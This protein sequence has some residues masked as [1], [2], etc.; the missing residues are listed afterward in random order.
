MKDSRFLA[1]FR[2]ALTRPRRGKRRRKLVVFQPGMELSSCQ[3]TLHRCAMRPL[4]A[5]PLANAYAVELDEADEASSVQLLNHRGIL[6]IDDDIEVK[7]APFPLMLRSRSQ[8]DRRFNQ[9]PSWGW[10]RIGAE[11]AQDKNL[12]PVPVAV[13]DTG[14]ATSHP[15]LRGKVVGGVNT[16]TSGGSYSDDN[17]HGT[18]V[19]GIIAALNNNFGVVGVAPNVELYAVKVLDRSGSGNLSDLIEGLQWCID[20][21]IRLV[22]LSLSSERT[23]ETF[24]EAVQEVHRRGVTMVCAAGNNGPNG[25]INYPSR[26][27]EPISVAAT[28]K[29]DHIADF[30]S[31][32]PKVDISAPGQDIVSTWL[33][34]TYKSLNGTSMATPFVTGAAALIMGV[35]PDASPSQVRSL[36]TRSAVTLQQASRTSQGAG[37]VNVQ[38]LS[39][40]L[41]PS[42]S[43]RWYSLR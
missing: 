23:N 27:E 4:K 13:I 41:W 37:L 10:E 36:L 18:H 19:A 5:L 11:V 32:G 21:N 24:K 22:N 20:N 28:T 33:G 3:D 38:R 6:R 1:G 12:A 16:I 8:S 17:G 39:Q 31:R 7:I 9:I 26:Y 25:Q 14:I 29:S 40:M 15:D 43:S 30:S 34:G 2:A 35:I 42:G